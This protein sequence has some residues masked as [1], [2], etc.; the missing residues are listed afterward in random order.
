[1][2]S[3]HLPVE[4]GFWDYLLLEKRKTGMVMYEQDWLDEEFDGLQAFSSNITL[5]RI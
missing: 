2:I 5:G 4:Q 3:L 1:M